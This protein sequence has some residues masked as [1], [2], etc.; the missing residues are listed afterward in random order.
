M[1]TKIKTT[2]RLPQTTRREMMNAVIADGYGMRGKSRWISEA[3]AQ[4]LSI[5]NFPELVDI[6]DELSG[7]YD[8]EAIYLTP[9][10]K[11]LLDQALIAVRKNYPSMEGVQSCI[12]RTSI[13]QRLL[14]CS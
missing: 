5:H 7:L 2:V 11:N 3:I 10:L 9:E 1:V 6:G 4:L 12:I 13:M 14:R 8:V